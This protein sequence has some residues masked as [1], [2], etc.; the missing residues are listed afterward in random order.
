MMT[1]NIVETL[2]TGR[3]TKHGL[4]NDPGQGHTQPVIQGDRLWT[5]YEISC[6]MHRLDQ[7]SV[8]VTVYTTYRTSLYVKTNLNISNTGGIFNDFQHW[9][10]AVHSVQSTQEL[11]QLIYDITAY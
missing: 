8:G 7:L 5:S 3:S 11:N 2:H 1:G 6:K 9:S 10:K 4:D